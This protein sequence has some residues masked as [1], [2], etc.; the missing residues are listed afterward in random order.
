MWKPCFGSL[1]VRIH[2]STINYARLK[3]SLTDQSCEHFYCRTCIFCF[4]FETWKYL[5]AKFPIFKWEMRDNEQL[6]NMPFPSS[7]R[8]GVMSWNERARIQ[9][10][11][12]DA[13]TYKYSKQTLVSDFRQGWLQ[14]VLQITWVSIGVRE[15]FWAK[16]CDK[17]ISGI[18]KQPMWHYSSY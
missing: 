9:I 15:S 14:I 18:A 17:I 10:F 3:Y 12:F 2:K 16:F 5:P 8:R 13:T 11:S 1:V 4:N 6:M 7:C